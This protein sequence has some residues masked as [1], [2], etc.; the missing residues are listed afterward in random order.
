MIG[1]VYQVRAAAVWPPLPQPGQPQTRV[2]ADESRQGDAHPQ[3]R[4][5]RAAG[6]R[7]RGCHGPNSSNKYWKEYQ[8]STK[9]K[10]WN[11]FSLSLIVFRKMTTLGR[12][13]IFHTLFLIHVW[14]MQQMP[15]IKYLFSKQYLPVSVIF[16]FTTSSPFSGVSGWGTLT[17]GSGRGSPGWSAT[18]TTGGAQSR[19]HQGS[20]K[21]LVGKTVNM[22][23]SQGV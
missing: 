13:Q 12:K 4:Q 23:Y 2:R 20:H 18:S 5:G 8:I 11:I 19:H 17:P 3:Q 7:V 22:L 1:H 9:S 16:R 21:Y 10:V 15:N 14:N 6:E